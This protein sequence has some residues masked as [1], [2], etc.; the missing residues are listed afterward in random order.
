[1]NRLKTLGLLLL[2]FSITGLIVESGGF[3]AVSGDRRVSID[4]E[5]E[6]SAYVGYQSSDLTDVENGTGIVLVTIT[7]QLPD[8]I[9][10]TDVTI[11]AGGF[12]ISD[13]TT[14]TGISPGHTGT[15]RGT[16][17]CTPGETQEI[18]LSVTVSGSDVTVRLAG[19]TA[20][21]KFRIT[22]AS[23]KVK[24]NMSG[25]MEKNNTL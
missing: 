24:G 15:V 11:E 18:E 2:F 12:T 17:E 6:E 8:D 16:V 23:K 10:V 14:P 21:R 25:T 7:N 3:T 1:M 22:C 4:V 20:T 13:L 19:D 5:N 9:D